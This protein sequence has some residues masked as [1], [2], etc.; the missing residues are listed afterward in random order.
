M[1]RRQP[2]TRPD[3][4]IDFKHALGAVVG[5]ITAIR[6]ENEARCETTK[7]L[8]AANAALKDQL[9]SAQSTVGLCAEAF[10]EL[11][12]QFKELQTPPSQ[13]RLHSSDA[14]PTM[15]EKSWLEQGG[16]EMGDG[17]EKQFLI[18]CAERDKLRAHLREALSSVED[19]H[20]RNVQ[21][22]SQELQKSLQVSRAT[23]AQW[24]SAVCRAL[25]AEKQLEQVHLKQ[26]KNRRKLL[27][28]KTQLNRRVAAQNAIIERQRRRLEALARR[29]EESETE[30]ALLKESLSLSEQRADEALLREQSVLCHESHRFKEFNTVVPPMP[31][32]E[33]GSVV[34]EGKFAVRFDRADRFLAETTIDLLKREVHRLKAEKNASTGLRADLEASA[35]KVWGLQQVISS[36]DMQ[37]SEM[38]K[39]I[40][41]LERDFKEQSQFEEALLVISGKSPP[42][43]TRNDKPEDLKTAAEK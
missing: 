8:L 29:C 12:V 19:I 25:K 22:G 27:N 1:A 36:R 4:G 23:H 34:P 6:K 5:F 37:I 15:F 43:I 7:G 38:K 21:S 28:V 30:I 41:Q 20:A 26:V 3:Q 42:K 18:V 35:E 2:A 40:L 16:S 17:L 9:R 10:R 32:R 24:E 39:Q 33:K 13:S 31:E 14:V 11:Q